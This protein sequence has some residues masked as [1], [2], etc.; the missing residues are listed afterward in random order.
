MGRIGRRRK[1]KR[2]SKDNGKPKGRQRVEDPCALQSDEATQVGKEE[3]SVGNHE[4]VLE[5]FILVSRLF[6]TT[7]R[8]LSV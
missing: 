1:E 2:T 4:V 7:S 6:G 5:L 3:S 8:Y